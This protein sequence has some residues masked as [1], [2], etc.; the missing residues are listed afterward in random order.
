M[1]DTEVVEKP[2]DAPPEGGVS[3]TEPEQPGRVEMPPEVQAK[4]NKVYREMQDNKR[5]L[6][7]LRDLNGALYAKLEEIDATRANDHRQTTEAQLTDQITKATQRGDWARVS[8]L[9]SQLIDIKAEAKARDVLKQ[10]APKAKPVE[11]KRTEVD[12]DMVDTLSNWANELDEGMNYKRPYAQVGHPL[13]KKAAALGQALMDDP[14]YGG[15][16]NKVLAELDRQMTGGRTTAAVLP[17][18][19]RSVKGGVTLTAEQKEVARRMGIGEE[20]YAKQ[21]EITRR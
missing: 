11:T 6:A 12:P 2:A 14:A 8:T 9:N 17:S 18:N 21:L 16:L 19:S 7:D 15:D 4:F 10:S 20:K 5:A 3:T 13:Q 1:P